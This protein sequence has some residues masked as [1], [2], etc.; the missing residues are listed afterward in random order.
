MRFD[1]LAPALGFLL[2]AEVY[3]AGIPTVDVGVIAQQIRSYQQQLRDFETQLE[4]VGINS[5]QLTVLNKQFSQ[6][7]R[8]YNDY[9]QQVKGLHHVISRKDWNDLFQALRNQYGVSAYSRVAVMNTGGEAGRQE[10]DAQVGTLYNVPAKIPDV[11]RQIEAVSLDSEPWVIHAEKQRA[12]YEAYR[13]QLEIAKDSNRELLERYRK[14]RI[15]KDNF[16]LADKSDLN[17]L[18]TGVTSNFHIIDELQALNKIQSQRLLHANH[19]YMQALSAAEAQRQ[20]EVARLERVVNE[21]KPARSFRWSDLNV[22]EA[23]KP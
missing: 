19:E 3:S 5:E 15:T 6:T 22:L 23:G 1:M 10:I 12:R 4:Q 17:A 2:A 18:Q 13:D 9:L 16:N 20:A 11:R 21:N 7:I 8:E 14:I